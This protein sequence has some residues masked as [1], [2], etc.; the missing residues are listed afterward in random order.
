[1]LCRR[2]F[3]RQKQPCNI[4]EI[5]S[6]AWSYASKGN[7]IISG[8]VILLYLAL[9]LCQIAH[10]TRGHVST[11]AHPFLI[12]GEIT[13]LKQMELESLGFTFKKWLLTGSLFLYPNLTYWSVSI[14]HAPPPSPLGVATPG[15]VLIQGQKHPPGTRQ[16]RREVS[17]VQLD[18]K[19]SIAFQQMCFLPVAGLRTY[20][21][22]G[23]WFLRSLELGE[24]RLTHS[25]LHC[26]CETFWE[27]SEAEEP[28]DFDDALNCY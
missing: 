13:G 8:F 10:W 20:A 6:I 18:F 23:R 25:S 28:Q 5:S 11:V 21:A 9:F 24:G 3:S 17:K 12:A 19:V 15:R 22:P 1:M 27:D 4:P 16:R 14:S 2:Q 7:I 26:M